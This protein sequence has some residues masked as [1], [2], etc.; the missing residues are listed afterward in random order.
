MLS[1]FKAASRQLF[2]LW[3]SAKQH[4]PQGLHGC[5]N[6]Y[7]LAA[8][9]LIQLLIDP[10]SAAA[11]GLN[12]SIPVSSITDQIVARFSKQFPRSVTRTLPY[13]TTKLQVDGIAIHAS[14]QTT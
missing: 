14:V 1:C 9:L 4:K 6:N 11:V 5:C 7:W 8:G 3:G 10:Y 13:R 2:S 12:F